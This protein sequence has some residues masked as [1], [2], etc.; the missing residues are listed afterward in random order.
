M[1]WAPA[2]KAGQINERHHDQLGHVSENRRTSSGLPPA[3]PHPRSQQQFYPPERQAEGGAERERAQEPGFPHEHKLAV[4][5]LEYSS[6]KPP[7]DRRQR[8]MGPMRED[9]SE[10]NAHLMP[11]MVP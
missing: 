7:W 4:I 5:S 3:K 1:F 8:R 2:R 11:G 6:R 9:T 10:L